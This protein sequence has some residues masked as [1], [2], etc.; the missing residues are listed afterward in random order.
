MWD[1]TLR[2]PS[3]TPWP[4]T[5]SCCTQPP[6]PP[7]APSETQYTFP[8]TGTSSQ[9]MP[10]RCGE[11]TLTVE[12]VRPSSE[13][14]MFALATPAPRRASSMGAGRWGARARKWRAAWRSAARAAGEGSEG[15]PPVRSAPPQAAVG[16]PS[17][18]AARRPARVWVRGRKKGGGGAAKDKVELIKKRAERSIG[19]VRKLSKWKGGQLKS[20]RA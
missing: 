18:T 1:S 12:G 15:E 20:A 10:S 14:L 8:S 9:P 2:S 16:A 6:P 13:K 11:V 7:R 19:C 3:G 17:S 5:S 4:T